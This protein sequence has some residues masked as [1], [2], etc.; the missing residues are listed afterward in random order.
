[1]ETISKKKKLISF[2]IF[3][4][5]ALPSL[6]LTN[7]TDRLGLNHYDS[8]S[9]E[10]LNILKIGG[11]LF[12]LYALIMPWFFEKFF[13]PRF[14]TSPIR[15]RISPETKILLMSYTML[16]APVISGK[17]LYR[18]GLPIAQF[19]YFLGAGILGALVWCVYTLRKGASPRGTT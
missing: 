19:N 8:L 2:L 7:V 1:M 10:D 17:L 4:V 12:S 5:F 9:S 16:Y 15:S 18:L 11:I 13:L 3:M 14:R 6:V